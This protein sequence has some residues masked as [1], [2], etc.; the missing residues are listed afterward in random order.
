VVIEH[1]AGSP[2]VR[3]I[4]ASRLVPPPSTPAD[5]TLIEAY[6]AR[7]LRV[8]EGAPDV[9]LTRAGEQMQEA[10]KA[11]NYQLALEWCEVV[12][13]RYKSH[14]EFLKAKASLLLMLGEKDKAIEIYEQV[15][16]IES[17]PVVRKKLE[18]LQRQE[19]QK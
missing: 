8:D 6:R 7:G 1:G 10:S 5:K 14:P 12:L 9:S 16:A 13:A 3:P 4:Q 15:E 18:E 11:G 17:D 19:P 2:D